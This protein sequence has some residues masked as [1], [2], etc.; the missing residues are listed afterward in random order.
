VKKLTKKTITLNRETLRELE[1]KEIKE[2]VGA[3]GLRCGTRDST[4]TCC[5]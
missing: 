5:P 2:I 4:V 3:T 1:N